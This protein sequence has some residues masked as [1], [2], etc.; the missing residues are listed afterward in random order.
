MAILKTLD[1]VAE[2]HWEDTDT[3]QVVSQRDAGKDTVGRNPSG[4]RMNLTNLGT[5]PSKESKI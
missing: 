3:G 1:I 2:D 4:I 5:V